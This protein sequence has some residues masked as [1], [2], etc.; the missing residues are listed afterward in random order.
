MKRNKNETEKY[1]DVISSRLSSRDDCKKYEYV[2]NISS[3]GRN[4]LVNMT[5]TVYVYRSRYNRRPEDRMCIL[6]FIENVIRGAPS[7]LDLDGN[8][9]IEDVQL[10]D[11]TYRYSFSADK[12][13]RRWER[14]IGG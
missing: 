5:P 1:L 4:S 14:V 7:V 12:K 9:V 11:G 13:K 3:S 10:V 8:I 6:C 2:V